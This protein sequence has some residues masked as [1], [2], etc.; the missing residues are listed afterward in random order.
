MLNRIFAWYHGAPVDGD[1]VG[2]NSKT[3][4]YAGHGRVGDQPLHGD[5]Q[6]AL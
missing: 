5:S 3:T 4:T 1:I 2:A 6:G